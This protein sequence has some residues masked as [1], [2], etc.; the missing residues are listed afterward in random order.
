L[1]HQPLPQYFDG[2]GQSDSATEDEAWVAWRRFFSN[3]WFGR[4]WILQEVLLPR[5]NIEVVC[6]SSRVDFNLFIR[7]E[8]AALQN[9][10]GSAY[11]CR[12]ADGLDQDAVHRGVHF[13]RLLESISQIYE[14]DQKLEL[15]DL[16]RKTR[17][18]EATDPRDK[19]FALAALAID[20]HAPELQ[21][22]YNLSIEDVLKRFA[23][24]AVRE[25]SSVSHPYAV[26]YECDEDRFSDP[27]RSGLPS[28]IPDW[29]YSLSSAR[30]CGQV[31]PECCAGGRNQT[32]RMRLLDDGDHLEL[33]GR[34]LGSVNKL[35]LNLRTKLS[36]GV[37][38][39]YED[40]GGLI[41]AAVLASN[42]S[43][44]PTDETV[45][46]AFWRTCTA[47][48]GT[49][50]MHEDGDG[51]SYSD[52]IEASPEMVRLAIAGFVC[53]MY[54]NDERDREPLTQF[55]QGLKRMA[56][57]YFSDPVTETKMFLRR[58][59]SFSS[60]D[61]LET[62]INGLAVKLRT[63]LSPD[64]IFKEPSLP[65]RKVG[66]L[67]K[68]SC[69][70]QNVP[71]RTLCL[72]DNGYMGIVP[73]YVQEDDQIC[74]FDGAYT[75]WVV[76]KKGSSYQ[77]VGSCYVHGFMWGEAYKNDVSFPPQTIV[78]C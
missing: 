13:L 39:A 64:M 8:D 40:Y 76:R 18:L 1:L 25:F 26:I 3:D 66:K 19:L 34:F 9:E 44:Y 33:K 59:F 65:V 4:A 20:G 42:L 11:K 71:G 58:L 77:L 55:M 22:D 48:K 16:L 28:W 67:F 23:R 72:T 75:P 2:Y 57:S 53:A 12:S 7:A 29:R 6:G 17:E 15:L 21:P 46:E 60:N 5:G 69:L 10:I 43:E 36:Q 56:D 70:F 54:T 30:V 41:E 35:A 52:A 45:L 51:L 49:V 31:R 14:N 74:C 32:V 37:S 50:K 24:Y 68:Q 61:L 47:N 63:D 38:A 27:R 73:T 78:V 62:R